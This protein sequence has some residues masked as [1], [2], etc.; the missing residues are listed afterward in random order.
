VRKQVVEK[1][2][3]AR[4]CERSEAIQRMLPQTSTAF[5][6]IEAWFV[7]CFV[8]SLLAMTAKH[9]ISTACKQN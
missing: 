8:A 9:G 5:T 4:L 7:D 2:T 3:S 6:L 1:R